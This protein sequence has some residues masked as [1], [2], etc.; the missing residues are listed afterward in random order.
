M[1]GNLV[2]AHIGAGRLRD[3]HADW[4]DETEGRD[5]LTS[6]TDGLLDLAVAAAQS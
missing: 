2:G 5:Q 3:E 1:A 4:W 6:L